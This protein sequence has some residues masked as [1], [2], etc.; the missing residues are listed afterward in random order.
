[1]ITNYSIQDMHNLANRYGGNCLSAQYINANT[2]LKWRCD[3][4]HVWESTPS[5]VNHGHWCLECSGSKKKNI[6]DM[7]NIAKMRDGKC[8]SKEYVNNK[9]KLKWQ[10]N[11]GHIWKAVPSS[12]A[13]GTWCPECSINKSNEANKLTIEEMHSIAQKRR[14]KCL[15]SKYINSN[16][17]LS[18]Q[19][20]KG[21]TW[22][23]TPTHVKNGTWC[24]VCIGKYQDISDMHK[25]AEARGGKCLSS[26][27]IN[28]RTKLTWQ[29]EKGHIWEAT[30]HN[31]KTGYWCPV[32]GG[33]KKLN[34]LHMQRMAEN[35]G[36]RC[37][38]TEYVNARTKLRWQCQEGHVWE[39]VPDSIKR[40]SWCPRCAA[41]LGERI[42]RAFF[43]QIFGLDFPKCRPEWLITSEGNR[44]E[45]D[46]FCEPL[47]IAFEY[48]GIQHFERVEWF[49][50]E[51]Q[52]R[53]VQKRDK[54]KTN[55]CKK[56]G[57]L[58]LLVPEIGRLIDLGHLRE[59]IIKECEDAEFKDVPGDARDRSI[60][61]GEVHCPDSRSHMNLLGVIAADNGGACLSKQYLG[62]NA[63]LAFSCKEGH[64][65]EAV[66]SS[67]KQGHWCPECAIQN[68][69]QAKRL[70]IEE[71][72]LI[73]KKRNGKCL[74]TQYESNSDSLRWQCQEGHIWE[75]APGTVKWG[76]WCPIC[77]G[78]KKL[79]ISAAREIAERKGGRCLSQDYANARTRLE[80]QCRN[81]HVWEATLDNVKRVSWCPY[82]AGRHQDID[83]M[84]RLARDRGGKCLSEAY[85][86][87]RTNLTWVCENGHVWEAVPNHIK[88]G[89]WCPVCKGC[90]KLTI[91]EMRAMAGS[92]AGTCLSDVYVNANSKLK[93]RCEKGHIWEAIPNSIKRGSWCPECSRQ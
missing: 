3:K 86:N 2:K 15:S 11:E 47:G 24:P 39:S 64:V 63:K 56:R 49:Q 90:A 41:G 7:K 44:M 1:M 59:F 68:R 10:C 80:W 38:S 76:A 42:C 4:G 78:N 23:A 45:L 8:L 65:W 61:L 46:G 72:R 53:S 40:G 29:C 13:R 34:M 77:A 92:R 36:G 21:H 33:S 9:T 79:D 62:N 31:I 30:P 81:G 5:S 35:L 87:N 6:Y 84:R 25:L 22:E 73:A 70:T 82:C 17:R 74:S 14:G 54:E 43:E 12:V 88:S 60:D 37:I 48:Q 58:L 89:T 66:P 18:W 16:T 27:Y 85:V 67:I 55:L 51:D 57:V 83:D 19:C 91:E 20:E 52:F 32:C 50:T 75:A 26:K 71:M 28:N 93:W 69:A